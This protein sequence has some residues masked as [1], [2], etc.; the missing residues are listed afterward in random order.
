[1]VTMKIAVGVLACALASCS[2]AKPKE[3]PS[4]RASV[5]EREESDESGAKTEVQAQLEALKTPSQQ[6]LAVKRLYQ[7]FE[8]TMTKDKNDRNGPNVKALVDELSRPL[9]ALCLDATVKERQRSYLV[10]LVAELRDARAEACFKKTLEDYVPDSTEEDVQVVLR[11]VTA[12]KLKSLAPEVMKTFTRMEFARAKVA[13]VKT[14]MANAVVAVV[15]PAQE[16]ELVKLLEAPMS[17]QD[18]GA[19]KNQAYWQTVSARALGEIGSDKAVRP[20]IKVILSPG[21]SAIA[22]AAVVALVKIGKPSVAP[23]EKLLRGEDLELVAYA[24]EQAAL[25]GAKDKTGNAHVQT[26]AQILASLGHESST[27]ALVAALEQARGDSSTRVIVAIALTQLPRSEASVAAFKKT[28]EEVR[29]DAETPAGNAKES[30]AAFAGDFF[31]AK[32]V[33]WLAKTTTDAASRQAKAEDLDGARTA[34]LVTA[35]KLATLD[36]IAE[37]E[38]LANRKSADQ[39]KPPIGRAF[40]QELAQA[41]ALVGACKGEVPCYFAALTDE[42]SQ[43]KEKQFTAI[44]AAHMIGILGGEGDRAKLVEALPRIGSE[45]VRGVALKALKALA[46]KGD[47]AAA[48]QLTKLHTQAEQSKD[49]ALVASYRFFPLAAAQLRLRA[50]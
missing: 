33:S 1:M 40:E 5:E 4:A 22:N 26:A 29:Y 14:D 44:K 39:A 24:K 31:D 2:E 37:A 11:A 50:Q 21:K 17:D 38:G 36:E 18:Q 12:L 20:L 23:A 35:L 16:G 13:A 25:G 30:M 46:P 47:I 45:A 49:E 34:A 48:D 6:P 9:D 42:K 32:L 19:S 8:D 10:K 43:T 7:L 3:V 15:G 41:K 27:P 28:F